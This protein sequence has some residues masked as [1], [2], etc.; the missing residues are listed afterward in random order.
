MDE[1]QSLDA[2][3]DSAHD[4]ITKGLLDYYDLYYHGGKTPDDLKGLSGQSRIAL[5]FDELDDESVREET[6]AEITQVV[7]RMRGNAETTQEKPSVEKNFLVNK[8]IYVDLLMNVDGLSTGHRALENVYGADQ[9]RTRL[10]DMI[11][12]LSSATG[13]QMDGEL[14]ELSRRAG[15]GNKEA[16]DIKEMYLR[17]VEKGLDGRDLNTR[18]PAAIT[19]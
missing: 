4:D 11:L 19:S 17:R 16:N 1:K 5:E 12:K 14:S 2:A 18:S 7:K 15:E 13:Y 3:L 9:L 6:A 10:S 8:N